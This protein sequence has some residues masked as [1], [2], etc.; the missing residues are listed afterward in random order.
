MGK[1]RT[2]QADPGNPHAS[3]GG[4]SRGA[5]S[6]GQGSNPCDRL[7]AEGLLYP[8]SWRADVS[9][10]RTYLTRGSDGSWTQAQP[11][12]VQCSDPAPR[13]RLPPNRSGLGRSQGCGSS[14]LLLPPHLPL[15]VLAHSWLVPTNL[16]SNAN[17]PFP[18]Q[19]CTFLLALASGPGLLWQLPVGSKSR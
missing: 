6:G 8:R 2:A 4:R 16:D 17:K 1:G 18:S 7:L 19:S 11:S 5:G 14:L 10:P 9:C 12:Q 15:C 3:V 13:V